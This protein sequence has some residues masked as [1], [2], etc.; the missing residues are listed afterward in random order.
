MHRRAQRTVP[1]RPLHAPVLLL[2]PAPLPLLPLL[3]K[4]VPVLRPVRPL[5]MLPVRPQALLSSPV[6]Q[7][8]GEESHSGHRGWEERAR[9]VRQHLQVSAVGVWASEVGIREERVT[10]DTWTKM[11]QV[12]DNDSGDT[13][14]IEEQTSKGVH[15]GNCKTLKRQCNDVD[16]QGCFRLMAGASTW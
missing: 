12:Q 9:Q 13:G 10:S 2:R 15:N 8:L 1:V 7:K 14:K 11:N 16:W 4:A 6:S 3:L 5:P